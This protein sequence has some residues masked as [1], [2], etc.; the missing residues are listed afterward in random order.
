ML[1]G[2]ALG[3]QADAGD[4]RRALRTVEVAERLGYHSIWLPEGH[5]RPGATASPLAGLAAFAART[6]RIRL[7]TT[8]IL[9]P[10]HHP[11]RV[12]AEVA[13]LDT[14]SGGR[15]ILGL[16]RGFQ[17]PVF[18]GFGVA[19]RSKRDRF[20]EALDA[21][22]ASWS[23]E[24]FQ[25]DGTFYASL[26]GKPLQVSLRPVQRPHPPLVVAAF[27][28]K[29]LRQAAS[30]CLPYLASPLETLPVLEENFHV[31]QDHLPGPLPEGSL[32][33]P[34]MRTVFVS[35]NEK[36]C[37]EVGIALAKDAL[38]LNAK[39]PAALARAAEGGMDERTIVGGIAQVADAIGLYREK[40]GMDLLVTRA[41]PPTTSQEECEVS[42]TL[43]AEEVLPALG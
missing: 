21:I 10:I 31:W 24:P 42:L 26:E 22:L 25:L 5:F 12:A 33:A 34:V 32:Q 29:G 41:H 9:L 43:L 38:R 40:L 15:V 36:R 35:K 8:S 14:L 1:L 20:D 23:G 7:A 11:L 17:T 6:E 28:P 37:R 27:G 39:A 4:W 18:Q 30:R 13:T 19:Q 16:G 3:G 2:I